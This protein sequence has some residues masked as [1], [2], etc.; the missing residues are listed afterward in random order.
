MLGL[1]TPKQ[2]EFCWDCTVKEIIL[3]TGG[4]NGPVVGSDRAPR[5]RGVCGA[6]RFS[7]EVFASPASVGA[8]ASKFLPSTP[9]R[10]RFAIPSSSSPLLSQNPTLS[11]RASKLR[12]ANGRRRRIH[13]PAAGPPLAGGR[14]PGFPRA[15]GRPD[16]GAH[17]R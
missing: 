10:P 3:S 4:L 11:E 1:R 15:P 12:E 13:G 6:H 8:D 7:E 5:V 9:H 14:L 2:I 17:H 16:Q